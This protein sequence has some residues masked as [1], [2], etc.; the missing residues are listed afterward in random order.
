MFRVWYRNLLFVR[1]SGKDQ[2]LRFWG[3][4]ISSVGAELRQATLQAFHTYLDL[5][6]AGTDRESQV[7]FSR[8]TKLCPW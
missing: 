2:P 3:S 4:S 1:A 6:A 7:A 5:F 8:R